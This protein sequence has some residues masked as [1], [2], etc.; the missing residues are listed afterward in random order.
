MTTET[1]VDS[2]PS[3]TIVDVGKSLEASVDM[4]NSDVAAADAEIEEKVSI[5]L[6][7]E[8]DDSARAEEDWA[9]RLE[10]N[11]SSEV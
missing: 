3:E 4:G 10:L 2:G 5:A 7:K 9:T 6:D 1:L 11:S 8:A